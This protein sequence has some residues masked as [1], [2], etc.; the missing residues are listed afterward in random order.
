MEGQ[1]MFNQIKVLMILPTFNYSG[2]IESFVMNNIR[3]M[4]MAEYQIDILSHDVNASDYVSE[5]EKFGGKVF[6]FPRFSPKNFSIIKSKYISVLSEN[7]YDIVHCHMA[8]AAF[9]YLKYAQKYKVSV[10]ILHS[11][12]N[13]AADTLSHSLRNIP[14]L[15]I[16]KK[17]ANFRMACTKLAGDFL[18]PKQNYDIVRNAIDY[19]KYA[20]DFEKREELR[21]EF[22]FYESDIVIGHTGRLTK[23]KNQVFLLKIFEKLVNQNSNYKLV[24]V[25]SGEDL[26]LLEDIVIKSDLQGK[27]QFFGDRNDIPNIL[28]I[29]DIF[30][31]PSIYEGLGISILEAQASGLPC[32]TST[33][34]P[35]DADISTNIAHLDLTEEI[36]KWCEVIGDMDINKR[37]SNVDLDPK[38]DIVKNADILT[39]FYLEYIKIHKGD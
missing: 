35:E 33:G 22:G 1:K 25:G 21:Q 23:V 36:D 5:V 32:V 29:F 34:V 18:F 38:Y 27:V 15:A 8:N 7:Q 6:H 31:F 19:Q 26:E 16:G 37:S 39:E 13:K 28:Q 20:F 2:G 12:Q 24:L 30:V 14:L 10:R 11:H 4:N 3:H 17:Y 9:L